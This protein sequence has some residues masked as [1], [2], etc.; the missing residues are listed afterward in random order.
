MVPNLPAAVYSVQAEASGFRQAKVEHIQLLLNATARRDIPLQPGV[1]EQSVTV[2][3]EAPVVNSE[4]PSISGV[5]DSH[6]V[7][8]LPLDGRT[9]ACD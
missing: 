2:T 3:A 8:S 9:R 6:S 4:T 1:L 7:E 5:V